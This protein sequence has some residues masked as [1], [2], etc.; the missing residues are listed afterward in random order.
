MI[1][2][3]AVRAYAWECAMGARTVMG[4]MALIWTACESSA[5]TRRKLDYFKQ[6]YANFTRREIRLE[7]RILLRELDN[8]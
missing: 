7:T 3:E 8:V 1:S 6:Q 5:D 4:A 2:R